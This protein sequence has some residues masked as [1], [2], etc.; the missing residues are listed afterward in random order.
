MA[1]RGQTADDRNIDHTTEDPMDKT[2]KAA[3]ARGVRQAAGHR[4]SRG[5]P[6]R[7]GGE[8]LV[9]I[10]ACG[11]AIPTCTPWKATGRSSPTLRS[12]PAMKRGHVVAGRRRHPRQEGDRVG[13]PWLYP[14]AAIASMPG[15]LGN[16]V[17]TAAERRL[18]GQRRLRRICAGRGRLRGCCPPTSASWTSR[19]CCC[20]GVTASG[21]EDDDTRPGNCGDLGHRH[22]GAVCPRHGSERGGR[23]HR[24][25]QAGA[26]KLGAEVAVNARTTDPAAYLKREIGGATAR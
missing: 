19:P 4:G 14:P 15:R 16:A 22:G 5:A 18:F 21:P 3:V 10:E 12:F 2:M 20:A 7:R 11:V 17:R 13:I 8:L 1:V 24:R 23:R 25:R 9:K 6:T 26:R